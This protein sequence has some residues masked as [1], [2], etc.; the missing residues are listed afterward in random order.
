MGGLGRVSPRRA[1]AAEAERIERLY[2]E[3]YQGWTVKHFHERAV[4]RHDLDYGYT[5]TK[6]VL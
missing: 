3:R 5:W 4:E 1:P 6:S 2:R